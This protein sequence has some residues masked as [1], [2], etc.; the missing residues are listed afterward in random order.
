[1]NRSGHMLGKHV[2]DPVASHRLPVP[3]D[4]H[5]LVLGTAGHAA[6]P[7]QRVRRLRPQRQQT[8]LLALAAQARL[9][10]NDQLQVVPPQTGNFGD[11]GTAVVEKQQQRVVAPTVM[12]APVRHADDQTHV[13]RFEVGSWPLPGLLRRDRQHPHVLL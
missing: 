3:I 8:L 1:M 7:M 11:P 5:A 12:R 4:E 6:Q 9:A 10:R 2:G 13:L